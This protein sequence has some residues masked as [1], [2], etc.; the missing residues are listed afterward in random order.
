M[1]SNIIHA[2]K[3]LNNYVKDITITQN[4][5]LTNEINII[6]AKN[7]DISTKNWIL[8]DVKIIRQRVKRED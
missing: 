8:N 6:N 1:K 2:K 4:N 5:K 7:A 3:F